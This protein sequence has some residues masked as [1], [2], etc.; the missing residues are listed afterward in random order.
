MRNSLH[1]L[2]TLQEDE[3]QSSHWVPERTQHQER[4]WNIL[5]IWRGEESSELILII[6]KGLL[7]NVPSYFRAHICNQTK[8]LEKSQFFFAGYPRDARTQDD[9]PDQWGI[10]LPKDSLYFPPV[11]AATVS[12]WHKIFPFVL[13]SNYLIPFF[14]PILL[15]RFPAG[16]KSF[17]MSKCPE[18]LRLTESVSTCCAHQ[19]WDWL[20]ILWPCN[21]C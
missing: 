19:L 17:Y 7:V 1:F 15:C 8:S 14:Q 9:R 5:W 11:H 13:Y 6:I 18:D 10:R 12:V 4:W 21:H 16:I 3:L 2:S 20:H